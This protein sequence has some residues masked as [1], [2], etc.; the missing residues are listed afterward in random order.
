MTTSFLDMIEIFFQDGE[1]RPPVSSF[2][3]RVATFAG[4]FGVLGTV[5]IMAGILL[6]SC[7]LGALQRC[8]RYGS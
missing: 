2:C 4:T 6:V 7:V 1:T 3:N 8:Q 5:V